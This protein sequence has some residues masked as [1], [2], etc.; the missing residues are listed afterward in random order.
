M[1]RSNDATDRLT[2][3]LLVINQVAHVAEPVDLDVSSSQTVR[4]AFFVRLVTVSR[5]TL[6]ALPWIWSS[7][8][9]AHDSRRFLTAG[10]YP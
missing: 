7:L 4:R 9:M 10:L 5:G 6:F 8:L 1:Q 2:Q 3:Y